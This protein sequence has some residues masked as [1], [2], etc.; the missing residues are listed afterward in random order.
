MIIRDR[1]YLN[2]RYCQRPDQ[3]YTL[4]GVERGSELEGFLVARITTFQGVRWGYIIDFLAPEK[5][6]GV[7]SSLIAAALEDFRRSE[8]AA[9]TCYATD[10]AARG[11]LFRAGFLPAPQREPIRFMRRMQGTREDLA[12]FSALKLWYLTAGDGD[13]EMRP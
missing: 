8:A 1:Q 3:T 6:R 5:E 12:K 7:L 4:Y 11:A 2:W 10:P 9:V 13:L